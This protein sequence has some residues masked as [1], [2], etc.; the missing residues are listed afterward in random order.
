MKAPISRSVCVL[1]AGVAS[2]PAADPSYTKDVVPVIDRLCL[3][4]HVGK[5]PKAGFDLSTVPKMLEAGDVGA[6]VVP[7]KP[8]NSMLYLT[9][10]GKGKLMPPRDHPARPTSRD[11][12]VLRKWILDGAKDDGPAK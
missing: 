10:S 3:E 2:A 5:K 1:V 7:G 8:E 12:A 9:V 11:V 6:A 4:C